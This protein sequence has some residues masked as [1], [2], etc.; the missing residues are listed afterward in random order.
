MS[1]GFEWD[2]AK[3]SRNRIKHR[4]SFEEAVTVFSDELARIFPDLDH[5][6]TEIRELIVGHSVQG[7]LLIVSFT[8]RG[9]RV[10]IINAR[11]VTPWERRDYEEAVS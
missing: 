10:R 2:S 7:K 6:M 4:V 3:A 5:S 11:K 9:G 8:E 1:L